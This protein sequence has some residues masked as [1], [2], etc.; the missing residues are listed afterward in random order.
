LLNGPINGRTIERNTV[1]R[2]SAVIA[3]AI[4][5]S[6][7]F[8]TAFAQETDPERS[9]LATYGAQEGAVQVIEGINGLEGSIEYNPVT[10][11]GQWDVLRSYN[12][13]SYEAYC[14][15]HYT[16]IGGHLGVWPSL[17]SRAGGGEA[18]FLRGMGAV[19]RYRETFGDGDPGEWMTAGISGQFIITA[20]A[21]LTG[22][23]YRVEVEGADGTVNYD[24]DLTDLADV[25]AYINSNGNCT[26]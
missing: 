21:A 7:A 14:T 15:A 10:S 4:A 5:G 18:L 9:P 12:G 3:G 16:G 8:T 23:R 17:S 11:V 19:T 24:I 2:K 1:M 13:E 26:A 20:P 25:L 22:P 6:I